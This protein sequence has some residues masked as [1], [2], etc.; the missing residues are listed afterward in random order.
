MSTINSSEKLRQKLACC[1]IK[2]S[3]EQAGWFERTAS[4]APSGG[5]LPFL[6]TSEYLDAALGAGE[7][8]REAILKQIIPDIREF[9]FK[10]YELSDPLGEHKYSP[11]P[12]FIHRYPD[13]ALFLVTDHCASFCRHCFRR[14]FSGTS[15]GVLTDEQLAPMLDY[16][17]QHNEITEV[18]FTGGDPLTLSDSRIDRLLSDVKSARPDL[19]IRICS[20][21]PVVKPSRITAKLTD[22]LGSYKGIWFITHFN[23][24]AELTAE[25]AAALARLRRGGIPILNQTVL[26]RGIND[27]VKTLARL[28]NALLVNGVKPYYLFQGDLAAG[29]SHFRVPLTEALELTA[30]LK[31][32]VSG[33]AMPRFAVDLP[34]GGGKIT[35]PSESHE[36]RKEGEYYVVKGFDNEEYRYP[37]Y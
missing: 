26:L 33:M 32:R 11:F 7:D 37:A 4:E 20:R 24:P 23:H 2:L 17:R 16:L 22:V 27:R 34:G 18:L 19:V 8:G 30:E 31:Q 29:T 36:I 5:F 9:D 6:T 28:F 14:S 1:N 12:R 10:D 15:A 13:R 3:S 25:A 21:I 35:L